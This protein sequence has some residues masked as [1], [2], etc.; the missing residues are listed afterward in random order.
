[1]TTYSFEFFPPKTEAAEA[2]FWDAIPAL[3][4]LNPAFMTVTYGA[5]GSTRDK[6]LGIVAE[7]RKKTNLPVA[8]H[9]TFI[10]TTRDD[11]F[12]V[13]DA[14]WKNG[15]RHVIALRGDLPPDLSWPLAH[16]KNYFQYTSDFIEALCKRHQFEISVAAYPEKHPDSKSLDDDIQ[17][18]KKKCDAGATRAITQFFF[19]NDKFYSFVEKCRKAGITTPICPGLLPVH[20]FKAMTRFAG[21]CQAGVPQWLA[22][23][24]SKFEGKPEDARK[25]AGELLITQALDL[26]KNGVS[27]IHFYTLNKADITAQ[28]C[29]A[30]NNSVKN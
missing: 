26:A 2:A 16:D 8:A 25:Y 12:A 5:G 4:A 18:L 11:V 23:G 10:N 1:M 30:L 28:A 6:T 7:L 9:L 27:H 24:F 22:D 3:A 20:D 13:T 19:E 15:T 29:D 21:R 17:A 14:L